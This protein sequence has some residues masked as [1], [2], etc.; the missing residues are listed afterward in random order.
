MIF[1]AMANAQRIVMP[2]NDGWKFTKENY[3][4]TENNTNSVKWENVS[5]PHTWNIA[6]VL[7]DEPGYYR[8]NGWYTKKITI[9][10]NFK[11]KKINIF[12]E[13]ANQQSVVYINGNNAGEHIGGYTGFSIPITSFINWDKE[14]TIAV[15]VNNSFNENCPPLDA[16]FSF[17]G[18]I[19]RQVSL[20]LT[21]AVHF[22][23]I[24]KGSNAIFI[25]TPMVNNNAASVLIKS[26]ITNDNSANKKIKIN[27]DIYDAK[28]KI[29]VNNSAYLLCNSNADTTFIQSIK[30]LPHPNLWS[31][32]SPYLYKV[33][34]TLTDAVTGKIIDQITNPL[35][36][37]W[38]NFDAAK[39]FFL[40]GKPL[41]LI[42]TSRH[43]DFPGLG[44]AL[45]KSYARRDVELIKEMG[46]NFLRVA[47]Y[48]QDQAVLQACDELGILASV[49]IPVVN[50]IT[51]SD[52]FYNN[53]ENMQVEMIR[54]NFNHP[55]IIIWCY[56]NEILLRPHFNNDK[57]RQKIYFSNIKKLAKD[58]DSIT[59]KEDPSRYTM[60]ADHGDYKRYQDVG[61]LEIPMIVGWNLYSGWYGGI[62][63][64]FPKFLDRF[65]KDYPGKPVM[66][67]EFGA[68][69]DPRISSTEPVRF[70]KSV[71]YAIAFHQSYLP[72]ILSRPFVA[73]AAVWNLADFNSEF[74]AE[75]MPHMNNKGLLKWDR[76]PK[77]TYYYYM[78]MLSKKPFVKILGDNLRGGIA[79]PGS[80][81]VYENI[82][83]ASNLNTIQLF[84]N[85]KPQGE[86]K[87]NNG[88]ALCKIPLH[89]GANKI[90]TKAE[91]NGKTFRDTTVIHFEVT[92][93]QLQDTSIPFDHL[94]L[95]LGA[96]RYFIDSSNNLWIPA[97]QYHTNSWG[98]IGGKPFK[99]TGND[100]LPYGTDKNIRNTSNDPIYQTQQIG[101]KEFKLD[102]PNGRYK[103]TFHFAEL[104]DGI[105]SDLAYNLAQ[106][107][108]VEKVSRRIFNVSVNE[109]EV[110][111]NF[112][113]AAQ[114]G[115]L[116]P[117]TKSLI[118]E[119]KNNTGI[120]IKFEAIEGSPVLNA[121]QVTA[122]K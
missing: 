25:S 92:A 18:G 22:S 82:Q 76:T 66:V 95:L 30:N 64:D 55:A 83:V 112:N 100:R 116:I 8:G 74:R 67:T 96:N 9:P 6:D 73:G 63:K 20:I 99:M 46:G 52:S 38:F 118:V 45:P 59:R 50:E 71:E 61:L 41:K 84:V 29:F 80:K 97:P 91:H 117:V 17:Y 104:Q 56:M 85:D 86:F 101:I 53:C 103:I 122:I 108:N 26:I 93:S 75:T 23:T 1:A 68:D 39:G 33:I 111:N 114:F 60:M 2:L 79:E 16:D 119:V 77:S 58:L 4:A 34:T 37:R 54:Q 81:V 3:N 42:G 98:Y 31:P 90:V 69:A 27:T 62:L 15:K 57:E 121:L 19:Y 10:E 109:K 44:N 14:N 36:F 72:E 89:N 47:H 32:E 28:G 43:Q 21:N 88:I 49:E 70:D 110:L 24:D 65:N 106:S 102:V 107:N 11:G 51:E 78:A 120:S 94:N 113:I 5:L 105:I 87:T 40:N 12:F 7:D 13:G 35:G 48:P 115:T